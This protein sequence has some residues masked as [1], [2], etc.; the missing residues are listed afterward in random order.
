VTTAIAYVYPVLASTLYD[1]AARRFAQTYQQF[2]AGS[3]PHQVVVIGNGPA[4]GPR[5][6]KILEGLNYSTLQ[7]DN[8]G[9][10]IGAFQKAAN[11]LKCDLLVCFGANVFFWK[12][13][14]LDRMLDAYLSN[15]PALYGCWG[16]QQPLPH[17]RTTAFWCPPQLLDAYPYY[18]CNS[19]RYQFEHGPDSLTLWSRR[20]GFETLQVT[21]TRVLDGQHWEVPTKAESLALDDR[22][23]MLGIV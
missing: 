13:G 21:W 19:T 23:K 16:F 7:H 6:Q 11:T 15:G 22:S 20:S 14:W 1:N 4:M 18:V 3:T 17:L 8:T 9:K 2:P 10:D 12:P 5:H